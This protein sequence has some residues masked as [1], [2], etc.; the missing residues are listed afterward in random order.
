MQY[1]YFFPIMVAFALIL[2][3]FFCVLV[4]SFSTTWTLMLSTRS[5]VAFV[6]RAIPLL[7]SIRI[8]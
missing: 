3:T 7:K 5:N 6:E 8:A 2:A 4:M 1:N